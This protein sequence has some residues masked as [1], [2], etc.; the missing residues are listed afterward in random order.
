MV[1]NI[2]IDT[3]RSLEKLKVLE[4][5]N[6]ELLIEPTMMPGKYKEIKFGKSQ[7]TFSQ[8][9]QFQMNINYRG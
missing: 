8:A 2:K 6:K 3:N 5:I 7:I 4:R 9:S 1:Y